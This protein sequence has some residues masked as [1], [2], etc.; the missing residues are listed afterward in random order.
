MKKI[1]AL[2]LAMVMMLSVAA[3]TANNPL[4]HPK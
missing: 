2:V 1:L 4:S 3:C